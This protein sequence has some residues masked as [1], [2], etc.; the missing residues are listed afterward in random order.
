MVA[1]AYSDNNPRGVQ[2]KWDIGIQIFDTS[3]SYH[4]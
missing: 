2:E 4:R 1:L 3:Y